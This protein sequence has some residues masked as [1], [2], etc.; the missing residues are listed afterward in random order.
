MSKTAQD[1]SVTYEF[2]ILFYWNRQDFKVRCFTGN[3]N[4]VWVKLLQNILNTFVKRGA[5]I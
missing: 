3:Y 5:D 1:Q 4:E 2:F